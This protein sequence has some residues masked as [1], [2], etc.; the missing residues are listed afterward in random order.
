MNRIYDT[1]SCVALAMLMLLPTS[2]SGDDDSGTE[3]LSERLTLS[4][5][6]AE[7]DDDATEATLE[8]GWSSTTWSI[9]IDEGDVIASVSPVTGGKSGASGSTTVTL[10]L[11]ANDDEESRSQEIVVSDDGGSVR[12]FIITQRGFAQWDL[13]SVDPSVRYQRVKGFGGMYNPYIWTPSNLV[14][15]AE[16]DKLYGSNGLGYNVMRLMIYSDKASWTRDVSGAQR[17]VKDGATIFACPWD[18]DSAWADSVTVNGS[19]RKHLKPE[20]YADYADHLCNFV[21]YMKGRGVTIY[22]MTVQN[23]P[24]G[25]FVYWTAAELSAFIRDYG[26]K[27][28]ATGVKL[29]APE[30][31][32]VSINYISAVVESEAMANIDIVATHTYTGFIDEKDNGSQRRNYLANLYR[33]SLESS[34]KS[35][36]MTEHLFNDGSTASF[37]DEQLFGQ[38]AYNLSHLAREIHLC[39][40]SYCS[41]YVYWYIK[42]YYGLIGDNDELSPVGNGEITKNGY[43]LGHYAAYAA[44]S[45]RVKAE[46]ATED[47]DVTAYVKSDVESSVVLTNNSS[48]EMR[49][50]VSGM[51]VSRAA[52][53]TTT[54]SD[55]MAENSVSVRSGD[56]SLTLP[57]LSIT[58][59]RCYTY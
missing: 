5:G 57:P 11:N 25:S 58:S 9:A 35:W 14:T 34:G 51:G 50:K 22:A 55:N 54:S 20:H 10:H 46:T 31:E 48:S 13:V 2:C 24:D 44:E 8:V 49:V 40:E 47:L 42:R 43:I 15:T 41:A 38:W 6:F 19:R 1:L 30:P 21:T 23:E 53:V 27:I 52:A 32:G 18:C 59:V 26:A 16:I 17:A 37:P 28:R 4:P 39:M 7:V 33:T 56:F 12:R 3:L 29:M 36:W 45:V